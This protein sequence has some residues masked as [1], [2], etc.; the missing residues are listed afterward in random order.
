MPTA[1]IVTNKT[2]DPD[3]LITKKVAGILSEKYSI[4]YDN[5]FDLE[6]IH[7]MYQKAEVIIVLGGDGTLLGAAGYASVFGKPI[8]GINLGNLG[9]MADVEINDLEKALTAFMQG[10]YKIEHRFMIDAVIEKPSGEKE[11]FSALNDVVVTRASYQ[12]MVAFDVS[13]NGDHL[14]SYQG[15]GL[16][17]STPTGSTA[18]SMSAGGPVVDP[19]LNACVITPVCPHTMSSKPVIVP[20]DA[21][22]EIRFKSTF[23]DMAMVTGD[24][25][26]G[27]RLSEGDII[28]I[29]GSKKT[30]GLIKLFNKSFYEILNRKLQP[31][32][33]HR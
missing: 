22:I 18:Y 3:F 4:I 9:F 6:N 30:T 14:A 15:D 7:T 8:L 11:E 23:D 19:T 28:T 5:D 31:S 13:V 20:G 29:K 10:D 1:A 2:K 26:T 27:I 21:K 32:P 25:Q 12:R 16:V 17:V 33:D 24:G